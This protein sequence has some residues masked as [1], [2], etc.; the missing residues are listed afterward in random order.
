MCVIYSCTPMTD[1]TDQRCPQG[2]T[3]QP[4]VAAVAA[5]RRAEN[6]GRMDGVRVYHLYAAGLPLPGTGAQFESAGSRRRREDCLY[7]QAAAWSGAA[8]SRLR[9][10][11]ALVAQRVGW[12]CVAPIADTEIRRWRKG[13]RPDVTH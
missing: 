1:G 13:D 3:A 4:G 6:G 11:P 9:T 5:R 10:D 2:R 12:P 8:S 7:R